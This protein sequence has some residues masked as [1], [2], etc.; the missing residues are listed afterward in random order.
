[1]PCCLAPKTLCVLVNWWYRESNTIGI[2]F[3][4]FL[5]Y[6]HQGKVWLLKNACKNRNRTRQKDSRITRMI[7]A[8]QYARPDYW[9]HGK[10]STSLWRFPDCSMCSQHSAHSTSKRKIKWS[11]GP[12]HW[13]KKAERSLLFGYTLV[14]IWVPHSSLTVVSRITA[15][16][17]NCSDSVMGTP[18]FL[19]WIIRDRQTFD[20][21]S[22]FSPTPHR[23]C[24]FHR[25]RRSIVS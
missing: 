18:V 1:M 10:E 14:S 16:F 21:I 19:S 6:T 25:K 24:S 12:L 20:V 7:L 8:R 5:F 15:I 13:H 2:V 23:A 9:P 11:V 17:I 22:G 4:P 3:T